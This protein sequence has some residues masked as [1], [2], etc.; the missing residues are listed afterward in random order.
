L[1]RV[2]ARRAVKRSGSSGH[3]EEHLLGG[4]IG[5][6]FGGELEAESHVQEQFIGGLLGKLF[7]GE[8]EAEYEA[9][10]EDEVG[11][12]V[13]LGR[14]RRGVRLA[15]R[16]SRRAA[17]QLV[18]LMQAGQRTTLR[19][20]RRLIFSLIVATAP[21]AIRPPRAQAAVHPGGRGSGRGRRRRPGRRC[22][23]PARRLRARPSSTG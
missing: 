8:L 13:R 22:H 2:A 6:L 4:I 15:A 19:E 23:P 16:A 11:E 9:E 5:G 14:A 3:Q 17:R 21:D 20:A 10:G 12:R 18:A 7:G 1:P